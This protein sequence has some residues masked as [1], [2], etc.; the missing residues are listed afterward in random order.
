[1]T[2]ADLAFGGP[3]GEV[4]I[5]TSRATAHMNPRSSR[6]IAVIAPRIRFRTPLTNLYR[7]RWQRK[8]PGLRQD[9][10]TVV[11]AEGAFLD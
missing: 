3:G 1:V 7:R 9:D 2:Q 11:K 6:A 10:P 5:G 4:V 8:A